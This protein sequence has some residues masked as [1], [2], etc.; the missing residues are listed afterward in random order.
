MKTIKGLLGYVG[1]GVSAIISRDS[2]V[3]RQWK[4]KERP[5]RL[6]IYTISTCSVAVDEGFSFS[7]GFLACNGVAWEPT[8]H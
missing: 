5:Q 4:R 1:F 2:M 7:R 3:W 6:V 8:T